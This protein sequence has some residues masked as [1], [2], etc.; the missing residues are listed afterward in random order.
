MLDNI[1]NPEATITTSAASPEVPLSNSDSENN[2][3]L[4]YDG[5]YINGTIQGGDTSEVVQALEDVKELQ[6]ETNSIL[7][8]ISVI[9][10]LFVA[11]LGVLI[12]QGFVKLV[13]KR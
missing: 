13:K 12:A 1:E 9:C 3:S 11:L 8:N 2:V 6:A 5:Y 4:T 10:L 7:L